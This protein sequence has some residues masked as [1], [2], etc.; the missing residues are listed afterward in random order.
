V[1]WKVQINGASADIDYLPDSLTERELRVTKDEDGYYV[2]SD[3]FAD[4]SEPEAVYDLAIQMLPLI[5]GAAKLYWG[6]CG[7][8]TVG[9][10]V[11]TQEDGSEKRTLFLSTTTMQANSRLHITKGTVIDGD[12]N[13]VPSGPSDMALWLKTAMQ[14]AHVKKAIRLYR[15]EHSWVNLYRL[16][17][18]VEED[19]GGRKT[20]ASLGWMKDSDITR[21][22]HTA[23]NARSLGDEA[24]HGH[25]RYQPPR[26]P[27]TLAEAEQLIK[28]LL[29]KWL[30]A[31]QPAS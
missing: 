1:N 19:V 17:E 21:F 5:E 23:N 10:I 13:V 25:E 11:L 27:M 12:G 14:D 7:P 29:T 30:R 22:T 24:R 26:N 4:L 6:E 20:I 18:V 8:L 2:K 28:T 9:A 15:S 16:Y 3:M 31:K